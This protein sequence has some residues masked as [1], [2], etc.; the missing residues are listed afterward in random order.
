MFSA[1]AMLNVENESEEIEV[2]PLNVPENDTPVILPPRIFTA[3]AFW[4][5]IE[6]RPRLTRASVAVD[7]PVPPSAIARSSIPDTDPL[8]IRT[9]DIST[10][11]DTAVRALPWNLMFPI[12]ADTVPNFRAVATPNPLV[13]AFSADVGPPST[14][15]TWLYVSL[16]L[17]PVKLA[18]M[19]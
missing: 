1:L 15:S 6:P 10:K 16:I 18:T 7:A 8:V 19:A 2:I 5:A 17:D 14:C 13:T 3:L 11:P 12:D 4:I 9:L